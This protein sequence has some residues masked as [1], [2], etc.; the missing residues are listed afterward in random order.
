M[1]SSYSFTVL[2]VFVDNSPRDWSTIAVCFAFSYTVSLDDFAMGISVRLSAIWSI[3]VGFSKSISRV[4]D[5]P[6]MLS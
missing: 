5:Y 4:N 3:S 2:M 1:K 6:T